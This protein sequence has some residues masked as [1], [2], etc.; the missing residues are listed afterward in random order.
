MRALGAVI[1]RLRMVIPRL[2]AGALVLILLAGSAYAQPQ[3]PKDFVPVDETQ[4]GEQIPA[5][6]LIAGAY[7]FI[8]AGL[9]GYLWIIGKRLQK[10]EAELGELESRRK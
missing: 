1:R 7:G 8:W 10:V 4:P 2:K 6:P 5:L 3:P 9:L